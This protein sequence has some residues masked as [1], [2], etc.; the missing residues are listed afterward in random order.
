MLGLHLSTNPIQLFET[1]KQTKKRTYYGFKAKSY[2]AFLLAHKVLPSWAK[3]PQNSLYLGW[4]RQHLCPAAIFRTSKKTYKK[5]HACIYYFQTYHMKTVLACRKC[6]LKTLK[7]AP[8][9]FLY[10]PFHSIFNWLTSLKYQKQED[11][12]RHRPLTPTSDSFWSQLNTN[13]VQIPRRMPAKPEWS[14]ASKT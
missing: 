9:P 13:T 14:K 3:T 5:Q 8:S 7:Y 1:N 10:P 2:I 6:E 11:K 4:G 12:N